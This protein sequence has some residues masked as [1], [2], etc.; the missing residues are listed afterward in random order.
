MLNTAIVFVSVFS[1]TQ[2]TT[3]RTDGGM[4]LPTGMKVAL[5]GF[6]GS[7]RLVPGER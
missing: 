4:L 6:A 7:T 3:D 5:E 1:A 2:F